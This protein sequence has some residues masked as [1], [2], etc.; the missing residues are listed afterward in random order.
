[1]VVFNKFEINIKGD[2]I[3]VKTTGVEGS[4]ATEF[5]LYTSKTYKNKSQAY[6]LSHLITLNSSIQ[7]FIIK[8]SDIG[9]LYFDDIYVG[10]ILYI[11]PTNSSVI[12]YEKEAVVANLSKIY[13]HTI[14][15]ASS[16]EVHECEL[17]LVDSKCGCVNDVLHTYIELES[18]KVL[19]KNREYKYGIKMYT[20]L[21][22]KCSLQYIEDYDYNLYSGFGLKTINDKIEE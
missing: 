15:S 12:D 16:L 22:E 18:V 11:L 1:M 14:K 4:Y 9:E 19:L 10:E 21:K 3:H 17:E 2:E 8:A 20:S 5:R 6:T 7:E 13:Y